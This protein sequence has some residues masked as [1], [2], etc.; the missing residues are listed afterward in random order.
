M[1]ARRWSAFPVKKAD[2]RPVFAGHAERVRVVD[3]VMR[4]TR[5]KTVSASPPSRTGSPR[6]RR[7][8]DL[9][10]RACRRGREGAR[11]ARP[12][13]V[14]RPLVVRRR[15]K[16]SGSAAEPEPRRSAASSGAPAPAPRGACAGRSASVLAPPRRA[17]PPRSRELK[18]HRPGRRRRPARPWEVEEPSSLA[19]RRT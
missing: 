6:P 12:A 13:L 19:R 2:T 11:R 5:R 3:G 4:W 16:S 9:A 8:A 7:R 14:R 1:S 10:R 15:H 17:R 18:Q